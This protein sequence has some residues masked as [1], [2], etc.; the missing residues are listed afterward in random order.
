MGSCRGQR[1]MSRRVPRLPGVV[2]VAILWCARASAQQ[3]VQY[4]LSFPAPQHRWVQVEVRFPDVPPATLELRMSR[5]SPGRYA[6]HE[7][8]KNVFDVLATMARA[9]ARRRRGRIRITGTSPV[10]TA[11]S[12]SSTRCSAIAPMAPISGS[13]TRT[14]ISICR[15]RLCGRGGFDRRPV[16]S[17]SRCRRSMVAASARSCNPTSDPWAFTAPNLQ[18]LMDSPTDLSDFML[19]EFTVTNRREGATIRVR[20]D[21]DGTEAEVDAFVEGRRADRQRGGCGVRR[22][23]DLRDQYLH[24]PERLSAVGGGDGMEHRNS[25]SLTGVAFK[26]RGQRAAFSAPWRTSSSTPG[27]WSGCVRSASSRSTSRRPT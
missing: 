23:S 17:R 25:T 24:V 13:T 4:K 9:S 27:I 1:L 8:A 14:R 22:V 6:L 11:R 15:R 21:H 3:P 2:V 5:S 10:T 26:I 12:G 19:R 7:F 20:V 18:Y 16:R